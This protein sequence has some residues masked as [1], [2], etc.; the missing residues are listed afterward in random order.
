M[1]TRLAESINT[2]GHSPKADFPVSPAEPSIT[3]PTNLLQDLLGALQ[4]L[5][6]EVSQLQAERDQDRQELAALRT[7]IASLESLQEQDITRVCMDIAVDRRRLAALECPKKEPSTTETERI[8]RIEKLCQDSPGHVISL[9]ELRGRMEIDK[10]VLSRLLKKIDRDKF[11][12]RNSS[13]DKR[14]RYLCRRSEV[15]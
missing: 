10:A 11:Y 13:T 2:F 15:R 6:E 4:D 5:K 1:D 3:V 14:I 8:E 12:L 7:K 9:S